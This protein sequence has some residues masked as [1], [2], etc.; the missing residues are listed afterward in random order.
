M[1]VEYKCI[2][3]DMIQFECTDTD[4]KV[5]GVADTIIGGEIEDTMVIDMD[6]LDEVEDS[7]LFKRIVTARL[8]FM[9]DNYAVQEALKELH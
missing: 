8:I 9:C 5:Y 2:E 4:G 6:T 7:E 3:Y 1:E